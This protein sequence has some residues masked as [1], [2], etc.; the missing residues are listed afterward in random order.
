MWGGNWVNLRYV[1]E[2]WSE[3]AGFGKWNGRFE[4][5]F[6]EVLGGG[7]GHDLGLWEVVLGWIFGKC[8]LNF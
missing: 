7:F 3:N 4:R 1:L 6:V 8:F 2:D 5:G